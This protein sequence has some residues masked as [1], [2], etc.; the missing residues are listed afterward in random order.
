MKKLHTTTL[1][2]FI[3]LFST[4]CL[5][6]QNE[7]TIEGTVKD[8][9]GA[10]FGASVT[11]K[12]GEIGTITDFDG[13]YLLSVPAGEYE[14]EVSYIGYTTITQLVSVNSEEVVTMDFIL[15]EGIGLD[16]VII[17][18]SRS[19]GRTKL[20]SAVPVDIINVSKLMEA[21][22][23]TNINQ[24]LNYVAPSF[25]SNT[26]TISDGTDHIDP[27]SLRGLGPD[28][29]LVLVN[30]KRRHTSSLVNVNGTFGRGNVGTDLNAIPAAAIERIEILRDG[31][32][33][34]YGSDAIA[35]VINLILKDD[36]NQFSA[37]VGTGAYFSSEIPEVDKSPDGE[38]VQ[39]NVNY[40]AAIGT[41]GGY[42]N[43]TGFFDQRD[44]TN[45]MKEW[46]A[47]IFSIF[48]GRERTGNNDLYK[49]VFDAPITP[50]EQEEIDDGNITED[51]TRLNRDVTD[52]EL[53]AR[54][55][56]RSDFNMNVGQSKLRN[57]GMFLNAE[58][59]VGNNATVYAFGG[60]NYRRGQATGFYRLP[61]QER[62]VTD[63][64]PNGFLPE[65][66]SNINDQSLAFGLRNKIGEWDVDFSNTFGSNSFGYYITNTN[67]A[68]LEGASKTSYDAGGFKFIQNTSNVDV[69]H[70]YAYVLAG[71]NL[72]F[73]AEYRY[74]N[75][76][77]TAGEEGSYTNYGLASWLYDSGGDSILVQDAKGPINTVF[78]PNGSARPGGS[79]VFPGFRP[80]NEL[81][82]FRTSIAA[83]ADLEMEI[84][85]AFL[86]GLAGRFENYSDFGST[87]NGKL[88]A[89]YK[90]TDDWSVRA[91]GSTGFR[92]PSLH[93]IYF[94][95]TSTLFVD[96]IPTET[97]TFSND[98][99]P[100]Q[101][102]GI[103]PLT[104]E[105]STSVSLGVT[106]RIPAAN[107]TLTIDGYIVDIKN[108]IVLTGSFEGDSSPDASPEDQ[109]IARLL[110]EANAAAANFFANAI[111]TKTSG[112]D[113][114][115]THSARFGSSSRLN[116]SLS[117]TFART[118]LGTVNTNDILKGKE[119]IYFDRTSRIYL[120]NAVPN[121]KVN[122]TF[123]YSVSKFHFM[124]RGVYF[125]EVQEATNT[126]EN[127]QTFGAK[128]VLDLSAGYELSK[129]ANITI[130]ASNLL[131][132]YPD[133][134]NNDS[135]LSDGRFLYSRRSQQFGFN[136]RYLFA[137]LAF[138]L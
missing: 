113:V 73:G 24:I 66:N 86:L 69:S 108:R 53:A 81:S 116:T 26:Q 87:I 23:Q 99:R 72:A 19:E 7:G 70:H 1:F 61:N 135:A 118:E 132:T 31:A 4:F 41:R 10:L 107:L 28:Q 78:G 75:Y 38:S 9:L 57:A 119:D 5:T 125:G 55:K 98:S 15:L 133:M 79:Q 83:Y 2:I 27:A 12:G 64:Y 49:D 138:K 95:S 62:T 92:A 54:G 128:V 68:S 112:I 91:A 93:Q 120:E 84:T 17:V 136:G 13:N 90:I 32:A 130:G 44:R 74:E 14:I 82:Q 106:G 77:I 76:E 47:G 52:Q 63:I 56:K 100:A 105:T 39:L 33:A 48:N 50:D 29:V 46:E 43:L 58:L 137:R 134:N 124:L 111:D 59:P 129:K 30:G 21:T 131:D 117:G 45:R 35:G 36:Y 3:F 6:A 110:A 103:D 16:E 115:V 71:L 20:N 97:G 109:E 37:S 102:L 122:L 51:Q 34:Q 25:S 8:D 123:D 104:E 80:E 18:G 121:T 60:L 114:V 96:G 42:V 65:I 126:V 88:A 127:A 85:E 67:N 40:G 101:L 89:R 22:P 11:I 94:N